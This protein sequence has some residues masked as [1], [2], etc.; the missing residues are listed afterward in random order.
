MEI[1]CYT[2]GFAGQLST[3]PGKIPR[4]MS[5][6][7]YQQSFNGVT[8]FEGGHAFEFD[9]RTIDT[10]YRVAWLTEAECEKPGM[11][12]EIE[13]IADRFD[14]IVTPSRALRD[15]NPEKFVLMPRFGVRT[16]RSLWGFHEKSRDIALCLSSK[17]STPGHKLRR[18]VAD[19]LS[20]LVDVYENYDRVRDLHPYRFVVVVEVSQEKDFITE[21]L[22]DTIALGCVPVYWG[23]D[24]VGEWLDDRGIPS[25]NTVWEL[26][27]LL[28][29]LLRAPDQFYRYYS[30][31][32]ERNIRKLQEYEIPEDWLVKHVLGP[33]RSPVTA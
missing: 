11:Y 7:Y 30:S 33:R 3:V 17:M 19:Q 24:T 8:I 26:E 4:E 21:H 22:L 28:T 23:C 29:H 5:W 18:E 25:W 9:P 2:N 12:Q 16:P 31:F 13:S 6:I 15:R 10:D 20:H 32:T 27:Q 14:V 1:N